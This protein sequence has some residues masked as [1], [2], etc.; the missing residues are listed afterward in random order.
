MPQD[1]EWAVADGECYIVQARPITTLGDDA[2][3][4]RVLV[5]GLGA[6][7]GIVAGRVRILT[8]PTRAASSATARCWSLP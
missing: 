7:P 1:I 4:D 5:T 3:P 8:S 2:M 6:S